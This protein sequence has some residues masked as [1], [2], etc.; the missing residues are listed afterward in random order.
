MPAKVRNGNDRPTRLCGVFTQ[1]RVRST[2][3]KRR[4]SKVSAAFMLIQ[5]KE[6]KPTPSSL[7]LSKDGFLTG[8]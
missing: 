5:K 3:P 1:R 6:S 2:G 4:Y 7:W 8:N